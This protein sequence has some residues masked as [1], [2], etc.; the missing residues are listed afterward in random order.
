MGLFSLV[1]RAEV[2]DGIEDLFF[3]VPDETIIIPA[4]LFNEKT[5]GKWHTHRMTRLIENKHGE[6]CNQVIKEA[7]HRIAEVR[8]A[9]T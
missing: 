5:T 4:P 3:L 8:V 6:S 1:R 7:V 9:L 2:A